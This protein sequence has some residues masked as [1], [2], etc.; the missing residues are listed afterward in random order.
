ME[1]YSSGP[2]HLSSNRTGTDANTTFEQ[3]CSMLARIRGVTGVPLAYVI[4]PDIEVQDDE[5]DPS[6]SQAGI[7]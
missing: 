2:R 3:I 1:G 6:Y 7:K 4:R 5:D